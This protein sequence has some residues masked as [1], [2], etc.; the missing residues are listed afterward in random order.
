VDSIS[1]ENTEHIVTSAYPPSYSGK[2]E[3]GGS[4]FM[5]SWVKETLS[6]KLMKAK[7]VGAWLEW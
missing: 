1:L 2:H 7:G 3:I 5:L 4:Q 6:Q